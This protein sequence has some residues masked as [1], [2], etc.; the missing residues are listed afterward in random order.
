MT[1][2]LYLLIIFFLAIPVLI[3]AQTEVQKAYFLEL[4][5]KNNQL[6]FRNVALTE[7]SSDYILKPN[8]VG[9]FKLSIFSSGNKELHSNWFSVPQPIVLEG[10]EFDSSLPL[11]F[12]LY[13]PYFKKAVKIDIYSQDGL[14]ILSIDVEK[15]SQIFDYQKI[16]LPFGL[17]GLVI[18]LFVIFF[19][20]NGRGVK[21]ENFINLK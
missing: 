6:E 14:K 15:Y 18:I 1:Y 8:Q 19:L 7:I 21:R 2:K 4:T 11:D 5:S 9:D 12:S 16:I 13:L 20:R 10:G 3:S 17:L